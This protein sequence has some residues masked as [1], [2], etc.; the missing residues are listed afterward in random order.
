MAK[1]IIALMFPEYNDIGNPVT[2][3]IGLLMSCMMTRRLGYR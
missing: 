3:K 2:S 1:N